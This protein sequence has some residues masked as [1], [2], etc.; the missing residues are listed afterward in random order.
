MEYDSDS[1]DSSGEA[2]V[3][4]SLSSR[5]VVRIPSMGM[6]GTRRVIRIMDKV[7]YVTLAFWGMVTLLGLYIFYPFVE[8][9]GYSLTP[10]PGTLSRRAADAYEHYF[11]DHP[12]PGA[13]L[14]ES[15]DSVPFLEFKPV[16]TCSLKQNLSMQD[17]GLHMD[18]TCIDKTQLGDGCITKKDLIKQ[19]SDIS[20]GLLLSVGTPEF[21]DHILSTKIVPDMEK[22][23]PDIEEC[24]TVVDDDVTK[25]WLALASR[26]DAM[27]HDMMPYCKSSVVS[28]LSIPNQPFHSSFMLPI[29]GKE[30]KLTTVATLPAGSFWSLFRKLLVTDLYTS[31]LMSSM[32]FTCHGRPVDKF[33]AE[34]RKIDAVLQQAIHEQKSQRIMVRTA[35]AMGT[36]DI[37]HDG[38]E[39]TMG[40]SSAMVPIAFLI[41]A[42]MVKNP[43]L[44]VCTAL[45]LLAC[46][47]LSFLTMR[48]ISNY[49]EV[50]MF[51]PANMMAVSLAMSIDYSLFLLTRF[52][53]EISSGLNL[54]DAL[55]LMLRNSGRIV[56][57]SGLILFL[58]F[59]STGI[60][61][62]DIIKSMGAGG[63]VGVL[64]TVLAA[65]TLTP[66]LLLTFKDFFMGNGWCGGDCM[67]QLSAKERA[68]EESR[69]AKFGHFIQKRAVCILMVLVAVA[70]PIA[71]FSFPKYRL[72]VGPLPCMPGSADVTHTVV[73]IGVNFGVGTVFPTT[74][75]LVPP[76]G[77]TATK[78]L[79]NKWNMEACAALKSLADEVNTD[80][81]V[82]P[83]SA[84]MFTGKMIL[85]GVCTND[86]A[87]FGDIV[88]WSHVD[89]P[90]SATEVRID[91]RLDPF[92][93]K[94]QEWIIRFREA[95]LNYDHIGEWYLDGEAGNHL[96]FSTTAQSSF[97]TA[98]AIM[99]GIVFVFMGI[100]SRSI[101]APMRALL[102]LVWMLTIGM[103]LTVLYFQLDDGYVFWMSPIIGVPVM[104]GL[105]LDYDIFYT[106]NVV[107]NCE[108]GYS[109]KEA[110]VR[111]LTTTADT[112]TAAGLIM[113]ISFLPLF[114]GSTPILRQISFMLIVGVLIDC[115]VSTKIVIPDSVALLKGCNFWPRTFEELE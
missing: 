110:A 102:C 80:P 97:K 43:R 3:M 19:V 13:L 58:C 94:G 95:M 57:L 11:P 4:H 38:I 111:A 42:A 55:V 15:I 76:P 85:N 61:P 6:G 79:R 70:V 66:A 64:S 22:L 90:Y 39:L 69:W 21:A 26:V 49:I 112:I 29:G 32:T 107:E 114:I 67:V 113:V 73:D 53:R 92:S 83:F 78:A 89:R 65:L 81:T 2:P 91:Y 87:N 115:F 41:V 86:E 45:S 36:V 9:L 74:L 103:G 96:D 82:P 18:L 62:G 106:E 71:V 100:A 93:P 34:A 44:I 104:I 27:M 30:M 63:A 68:R 28:F 77:T 40:L 5:G 105:G 50:S 54:T 108:N 37:M 8:S 35:T 10:L 88:R 109:E 99:M 31:M 14:V 72:S 20:R 84:S 52:Q 46:L 1:S 23:M 101:V 17:G 60:I 47:S 59:A 48:I 24:P 16:S 98:V 25:A 51:V 56:L 12:V 33:S 75:I 7:K